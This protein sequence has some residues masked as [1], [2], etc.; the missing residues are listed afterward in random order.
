M[1]GQILGRGLSDEQ[2]A[3]L[4]KYMDLLVEWN[5]VHRLTGSDQLN[6][7]A[8]NVVLDSLLFSRLI[9]PGSRRLLD[10]GS[11][12]GVPGI[13]LKIAFPG[14]EVVLV[15]AR[16]KRASFL[17]TVVR[18][19]ALQAVQ[20]RNTRAEALDVEEIGRF[21]VVTARCAGDLG[22]VVSVATRFLTQSGVVVVSGPPE[23]ARA[24]SALNWVEVQNPVTGR[25]RG[26][27]V[28]RPTPER[29]T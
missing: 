9:P 1:A 14:L 24:R 10:I 26:F 21:E 4:G 23:L 25:A 18:S 19:L 22:R 20:V 27:A 16:R 3:S 6:W 29:S 2:L 12:A 13:P 8:D 15:E 28:I 17:S 11:G 7:I 5:A